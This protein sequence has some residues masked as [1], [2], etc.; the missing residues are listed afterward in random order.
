MVHDG[1]A[2]RVAPFGEAGGAAA[3]LCESAVGAPFPGYLTRRRL[4]AEIESRFGA[5]VVAFGDA[6]GTRRVW[7]WAHHEPGRRATYEERAEPPGDGGA[8]LPPAADGGNPPDGAPV[9][10]VV[11]AVVGALLRRLRVVPGLAP[12]AEAAARGAPGRE[13]AAALHERVESAED[14]AVV[15]A[16]WRAA[17]GLRVLDPACGEGAWLCGAGWVLEGVHRACLVRMRSFVADLDFAPGRRRP[18][19]LV[20]F[21]RLVER[22][23]DPRLAP[24]PAHFLRAWIVR[25]NLHGCARGAADAA[26]CRR[27]LGRFVGGAAGA[28][29]LLADLDCNVRPGEP[30]DGIGSRAALRRAL[31]IAAFPDA[32]ER[33]LLEEADAVARALAA[34]RRARRLGLAGPAALDGAAADVRRRR[35]ALVAVL[36]ALAAAAAGVATEER[37]AVRRWVADH[38]PLHLLVEFGGPA[39]RPVFHLV[40]DEG[41][42]S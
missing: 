31:R 3:F 40:R 30:R 18:E 24:S 23:D 22:A 29:R 41:P 36:D 35:A 12:L 37:S 9:D 21:R 7:T 17:R 38:R 25:D 32:V 33:A 19:R 27:R 15:R 1:L 8:W 10:A 20:D 39:P 5:R 2:Y 26:R 13:L 28:A 42:C 11:G 16:A 6:A 34:L 14:P 4:R